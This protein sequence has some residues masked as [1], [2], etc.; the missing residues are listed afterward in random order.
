M[1]E[2]IDYYRHE[3][4]RAEE[5]LE[6]IEGL[7]VEVRA[8]QEAHERDEQLI[9]YGRCQLGTWRGSCETWS[10]NDTAELPS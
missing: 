1:Q 5:Y 4:Q 3:S 2:E 9:Q 8:L 6:A 7:E 10:G